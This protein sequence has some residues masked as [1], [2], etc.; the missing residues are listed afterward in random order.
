[1]NWKDA[2]L[3]EISQKI[4]NLKFM[5]EC[6]RLFLANYFSELRNHVD[7][8]H[9]T[10]IESQ[11]DENLKKKITENWLSMIA[12]IDSFEKECLKKSPN[13]RYSESLTT[14]LNQTIQY[15]Q[16]EMSNL[17]LEDEN[18]FDKKTDEIDDLTYEGVF[19]MEKILFEKKTLF[20]F[21]NHDILKDYMNPETMFGKLIFIRNEHF[22]ARGVQSLI[23]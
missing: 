17:S 7:L 11:Q 1:M 19:E 3:N 14:K 2:K 5:F 6:K 8:A 15:I 16:V 21:D 23:K 9:Y 12:F 18:L 10:K 20:W 22:G 13:N 4:E